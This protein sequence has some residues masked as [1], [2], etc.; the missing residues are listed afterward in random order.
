[1]A[2]R[3]L[4]ID[5]NKEGW[6]VKLSPPSP[7]TVTPSAGVGVMVRHPLRLIPTAPR[8]D[9]LKHHCDLGRAIFAQIAVNDSLTIYVV[10]I[11]GLVNGHTDLAA[12]RQT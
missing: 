12:R 9:L 7:F 10:V 3:T 2:H 6:Q 1:M 11:Y 8:T 4:E 5:L